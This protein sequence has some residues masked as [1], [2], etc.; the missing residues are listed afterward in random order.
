MQSAGL[1]SLCGGVSEIRV[2]VLKFVEHGISYAEEE[3]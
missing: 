1:I 3:K 2:M